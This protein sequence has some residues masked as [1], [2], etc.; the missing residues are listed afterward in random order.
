ML[1]ACSI[2]LALRAS[3]LR[4]L[5]FF[6]VRVKPTPS[7]RRD[8]TIHKEYQLNNEFFN[9]LKRQA[10]EQPILALAAAAA[11]LTAASKFANSIA[12]KQEVARRAKKDARKK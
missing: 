4:G 12:W 6:H 2:L 5:S 9:N 3:E 7:N 10:E 11:L 1:R 8:P